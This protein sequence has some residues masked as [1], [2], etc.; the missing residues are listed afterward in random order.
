[1]TFI[2][3]TLTTRLIQKKYEKIKYILKIHCVINHIIVKIKNNS[4][5]FN[6]TGS[7]SWGRK[8]QMSNIWGRKEYLL[9]NEEITFNSE[10]AVLRTSNTYN[11]FLTTK[12]P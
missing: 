1:L 6:K 3:L 9:F 11:Y 4:D 10:A 12:C 8:S 5:F 2:T 7:Q